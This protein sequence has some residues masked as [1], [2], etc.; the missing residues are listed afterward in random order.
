M[1]N[2]KIQLHKEI[3]NQMHEIYK[4]K[5]FDYGD[6]FSK[7]VDKRGLSAAIIRIEDKWNRLDNITLH[8]DNIQVADETIEDTLLD[9]ANYCILTLIELKMHKQGDIVPDDEE[10]SNVNGTGGGVD[11]SD[12]IIE[13]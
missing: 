12:K 5:N 6:S 4:Q 7:S 9:L 2:H 1:K 11:I 13:E 3:C 10:S 8:P